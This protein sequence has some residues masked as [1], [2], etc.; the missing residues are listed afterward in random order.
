M[1][2]KRLYRDFKWSWKKYYQ[3]HIK[4]GNIQ[5]QESGVFHFQAG[6]C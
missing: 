5:K 1:V 6:N 4:S 2:Y 3:Y